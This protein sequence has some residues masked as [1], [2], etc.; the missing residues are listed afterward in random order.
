[1][2]FYLLCKIYNATSNGEIMKFFICLLSFSVMSMAAI[3]DMARGEWGSGGGNGIVCFQAVQNNESVDSIV[4]EIKNNDNLIPDKYI[5]N[6]KS[7]ELFDLYEAKKKRGFNSS[8]PI[9]HEIKESENFEEYLIRMSNRFSNYND[10]LPALVQDAFQILPQSSFVFHN[11]PIKFQDDIGEVILPSSHCLFSTIAA[12]VNY[13]G[14]FQVHIDERLFNHPN[15]SRQSQVSLYIHELVYAFGRKNFNH[16]GASQTRELVRIL[17]AQH[18]SINER[19]VAKALWALRFVNGSVWK[20]ELSTSRGHGIIV[21]A[22]ELLK[23]NLKYQEENLF[24]LSFYELFTR[25]KAL[26]LAQG[27]GDES[28]IEE[29]YKGLFKIINTGLTQNPLGNWQGLEMEFKHILS[30]EFSL[31]RNDIREALDNILLGL[32]ESQY[33]Q[34][35]IDDVRTFFEW[36]FDLKSNDNDASV[37]SQIGFFINLNF[38]EDIETLVYEFNLRL[39]YNVNCYH[40]DGTTTCIGPIKL[41][42]K[43]P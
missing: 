29:S 23:L 34:S 33:T 21:G 27:L 16:E 2:T 41:D 30:K 3:L 26:Y 43:I 18:E 31:T 1:M 19:S 7:I 24:K 39:L 5:K 10:Y 37:L 25:A 20:H 12:Q 35:V 14:F 13:N 11:G 32:K 36:E 42:R 38:S 15:H 6:I 22:F 8:Q 40:T 28:E 17:I 9:I 4:N